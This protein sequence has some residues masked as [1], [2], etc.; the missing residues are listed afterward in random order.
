[1]ML[2]VACLAFVATHQHEAIMSRYRGTC[3]LGIPS[4]I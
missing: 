1:V 2:G 3:E 4:V